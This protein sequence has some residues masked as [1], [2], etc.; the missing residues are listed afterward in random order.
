MLKKELGLRFVR[1]LNVGKLRLVIIRE[2]LQCEG[3]CTPQN[4]ED[5]RVSKAPMT[6]DFYVR[7]FCGP[8]IIKEY[9]IAVSQSYRD[10]DGQ[11]IER[12]SC[13]SCAIKSGAVQETKH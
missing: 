11:F 10:D 4:D 3:I 2:A 9:S 7:G 12:V 5:Y 13:L 8:S 1:T 6:S